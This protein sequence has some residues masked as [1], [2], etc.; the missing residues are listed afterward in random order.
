MS[1]YTVKISDEE[2]KA[3]LT[4]MISIQDWLN[5]TIHQKARM[6][7]EDVVCNYSDKNPKKI[8]SVERDQ[9]IRD[10]QVETAM[11]K[12]VRE[13]AERIARRSQ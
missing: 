3:L 5:N 8:S 2:E 7:M 6:C 10:A 9:I 11:E 1:D 13:E 12:N 4:D